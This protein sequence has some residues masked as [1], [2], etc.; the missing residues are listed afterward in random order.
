MAEEQVNTTTPQEQTQT[1][2]TNQQR[3]VSATSILLSAVE[4]AQ[5]RGAY[6]MN[7]MALITHIQYDSLSRTSCSSCRCSCCSTTIR[8]NRDTCQLNKL[9]LEI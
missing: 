7:E 6:R 9:L 4:L 1:P 8:R 5:T 2:S 3:T